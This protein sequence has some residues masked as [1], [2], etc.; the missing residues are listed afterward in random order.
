MRRHASWGHCLFLFSILQGARKG[1]ERVLANEN[2]LP[3]PLE[4][5]PASWC[6]RTGRPGSFG[7]AGGTLI[8]FIFISFHA[9]S[10]LRSGIDEQDP[11][12]NPLLNLMFIKFHKYA[13]LN[14]RHTFGINNFIHLTDHPLRRS[15]I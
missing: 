6:I 11:H 2:P 12:P 9:T 1:G 13:I 7:I 5:I 8:S 15:I 4:N 10:F 14:V 3:L